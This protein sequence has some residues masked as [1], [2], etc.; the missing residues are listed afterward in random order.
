MHTSLWGCVHFNN[1]LILK[2]RD[3]YMAKYKVLEDNVAVRKGRSTTAA[4]V[5]TLKKGREVTVYKKETG[6]DNKQY[7][8]IS[9][10]G[11]QWVS[12]DYLKI[13]GS[14]SSK[15]S[16]NVGTAADNN[17]VAKAQTPTGGSEENYN[18]LIRKYTR[19]FGSPSR[20]T[21]KVDPRF[22]NNKF[23]PG[24]VV[25]QTWITDSSILSL[26]PGKVDYLPGFHSK[27]KSRFWSNVKDA[28]NPTIRKKGRLD[29]KMDL[30]GQ[31]YAFR[32]AYKDYMNIVNPMIRTTADMMGIGDVKAS[33]VLYGAAPGIKLNTFDY[34]FYTGYC[35]SKASNGVF[36]MTKK[37]LNTAVA[38]NSYIHFYCNHTGTTASESITTEAGKS[39]LEEQLVGSG[40]GLDVA[41]RNIEF[42]LGGAIAPE[43]QSDLMEVLKNARQESELLGGFATI[44]KNYLEGGR[45][46]F[47]K[48]ITGMN[49][50]KS[51]KCELCFRSIYGD[52][53]SIFKYVM[54]PC[55]HLLAMA[56]PKQLSSNMFTYPFLVR[57]FQR[58]NINMDLAFINSLEFSRGGS[59]GT[60]WTV[61]GLPTEVIAS[62]NITPLYSN[63]MVTSAQNPFLFIGNT[64]MLEYLGTMVGLDLKANNL[65]MKSEIARNILKNDLFDI[66][67]NVARGIMD[68]KIMNEV[69]KFTSIS[70]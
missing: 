29:R 50:E 8:N 47:P 13:L 14:K 61:D 12:M 38:D 3:V 41:A 9:S 30:N 45:L 52:K 6:V 55:I 2:R 65:S 23:A 17:D 43:A 15:G 7:G 64:A 5:K 48:M 24:R 22:D 54:I 63:M 49:Y 16:S 27:E 68:T 31:L 70:N 34:A 60:C 26:C 10:K 59:D 11:S 33:A 20:F 19:A 53:R 69:R 39:W 40:T 67:T 66:P 1:S 35:K 56:T 46:V 44:A 42:L 18:K 25:E 28:M 37:V 4:V 36:A 58:G 57:A 21:T 32:S 62:F 51:L